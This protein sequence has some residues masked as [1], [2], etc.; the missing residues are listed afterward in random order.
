MGGGI[1]RLGAGGRVLEL[2][3]EEA[4]AARAPAAAARAASA[5]ASA[6]R[7]LSHVQVRAALPGVLLSERR[8]LLHRHHIRE[9][10]LQLRMPQRVCGSALRV[11]GSGRLVRAV[12]S[13]A[14]DG[15]SVNC[16]RRHGG[17]IPRHS[18]LLRGVG[19]AAPRGQGG[20]ER[21]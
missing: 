19:A 17:G 9:H 11:Q 3:L 8:R 12:Q 20:A 21:S 6:Q 13:P 16:G 1:G 7:H 15:D 18:S 4:G 2:H 14:D 5:A 10:H